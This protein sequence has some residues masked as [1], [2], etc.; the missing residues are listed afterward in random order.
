MRSQQSAA[1]KGGPP[2]LSLISDFWTLN[3]KRI[4]VA[5]Y[6]SPNHET[7]CKKTTEGEKQSQTMF[8]QTRVLPQPSSSLLL[9][10]CLSVTSS[11][12]Q[13]QA[14]DL[15]RTQRTVRSLPVFANPVFAWK[16]VLPTIHRGMPSKLSRLGHLK[17]YEG[18]P[19]AIS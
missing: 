17:P 11:T 10:H 14:F 15:P 5:L 12:L 13:L 7:V 2:Y 16:D 9:Q 18:F 1:H 6:S 8:Y 3:F 19:D 4:S